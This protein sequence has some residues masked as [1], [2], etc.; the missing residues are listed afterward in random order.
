MGLYIRNNIMKKVVILIICV[1]ITSCA[2]KQ[3]NIYSKNCSVTNML[4]HND[5]GNIKITFFD[6]GCKYIYK[7]TDKKTYKITLEN[8]SFSTFTPNAE[9]AVKKDVPVIKKNSNEVIIYFA[10]NGE[11]KKKS[12][13]VFLY[14]Q[15]QSIHNI[16]SK[17]ASYIKSIECME[18]EVVI[19]SD[20]ALTTKTGILYNGQKYI[21]IFDVSLKKDYIHSANCKNISKPYA[22]IYPKRIR[23]F[24]DDIKGNMFVSNTAGGIILSLNKK[25]E[26]L[27][28]T[29]I[30]E[31]KTLT[32]Q[33]VVLETSSNIQVVSSLITPSYTTI[34]LKG[35][36]N[37]ISKIVNRSKLKGPVFKRIEI[38]KKSSVTEVKLYNRS[39]L[40]KNYISADMVDNKL[41]IYATKS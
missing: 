26:N 1:F 38:N 22:L 8:G 16:P 6:N 7:Q 34:I 39:S 4:L 3:Q 10:E 29:N 36:Y 21:D 5:A 25:D 32:K 31:E 41:I 11:K 12:D 24:I 14:N 37:M 9:P 35:R 18:K 30:R 40:L 2:A 17:E 28:V 13:N 27:L 33:K 20:G 19:E 23:Y 15:S